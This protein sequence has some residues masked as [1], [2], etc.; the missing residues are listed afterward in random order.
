VHYVNDS[1]ILSRAIFV[2]I[3]DFFGFATHHDLHRLAPTQQFAWSRF[4]DFSRPN[5]PALVTIKKG[6][7]VFGGPIFLA[8]SNPK[9]EATT[10]PVDRFLVVIYVVLR[11][12]R[13]H[14][15]SEVV[16]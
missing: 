7:R 3:Y 6:N 10:M 11:L 15:Y 13:V 14:P 8:E 4:A 9:I 5:K 16:L 1:V 2:I 12:E